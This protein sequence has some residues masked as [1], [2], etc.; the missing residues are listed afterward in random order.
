MRVTRSFQPAAAWRQGHLHKRRCGG[1]TEV[2]VRLRRRRV[3]GRYERTGG[4]LRSTRE[5]AKRRRHMALGCGRCVIESELRRCGAPIAACMWRPRRGHGDVEVHERCVGEAVP[6]V[7]VAPSS[8]EVIADTPG[9]YPGRRT[10]CSLSTTSVRAPGAAGAERTPARRPC[11]VSSYRPGP[12]KPR[13]T[14]K[15]Q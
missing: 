15:F 14:R 8:G 5:G 1:V 2:T 11:R 4:S 7:R 9:R 13:F 10:R 6:V 3:C 12:G